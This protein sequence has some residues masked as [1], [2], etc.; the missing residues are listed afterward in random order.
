MVTNEPESDLRDLAG[1][2]YALP[3]DTPQA[4][5]FA[6]TRTDGG[7]VS[8]RSRHRHPKNIGFKKRNVQNLPKRVSPKFH[9]CKT[10]L[11]GRLKF[12]IFENAKL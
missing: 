9:G 3:Q 1:G 8:E 12:R 11:N 10:Y 5:R 4:A 6:D 7:L 2:G